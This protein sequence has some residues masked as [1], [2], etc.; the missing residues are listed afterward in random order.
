MA[1]LTATH[2]EDFPTRP[3]S[4]IQQQQPRESHSPEV[5][6]ECLSLCDGAVGGLDE[7]L[8]ALCQ[9]LQ[10]VLT[11]LDTLSNLTTRH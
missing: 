6:D 2:L 1:T 4:P 7:R 11:A 9:L 10:Q 3:L 5:G 8:S